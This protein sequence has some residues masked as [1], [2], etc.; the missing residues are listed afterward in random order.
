VVL[1]DALTVRRKSSGPL[2]PL[3]YEFVAGSFVRLRM[4]GSDDVRLLLETIAGLRQPLSGSVR[5]YGALSQ[6]DEGRSIVSYLSPSVKLLSGL[7]IDENAELFRCASASGGPIHGLPLELRS[8]VSS[9]GISRNS[10][11]GELSPT[12]AAKVS[13]LVLLASSA[14]VLCVDHSLELYSENEKALLGEY[15]AQRLASGLTLIAS[16]SSFVGLALP[17]QEIDVRPSSPPQRQR[18]RRA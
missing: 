6:S 13:S 5:L 10:L 12:A 1:L 4:Q 2:G 3:Y 16:P 11:F 18:R 15:L 8:I 7:T 14:K 9:L 17:A